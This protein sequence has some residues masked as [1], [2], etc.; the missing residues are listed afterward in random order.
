MVDEL[1]M[2]QLK[3]YQTWCKQTM[4]AFGISYSENSFIFISYQTG[5]PITDSCILYM[6]RRVHEVAG[7]VIINDEG[8]QVAKSTLHG[9]RHTH[10]TI[11]LNSGQ[12]VKVI[13]ERLGNTPAMIY[14][15][16]GHVLKELEQES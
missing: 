7:L 8:E 4:L 14:E 16:Y 2:V 15:I 10:A 13:A 9:L 3:K 1:V 12:N 5:E 11:L 6:L